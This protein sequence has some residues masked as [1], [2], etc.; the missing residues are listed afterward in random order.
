MES[1]SPPTSRD[2]ASQPPG[3]GHPCSLEEAL[4]KLRRWS[5]HRHE[6]SSNSSDHDQLQVGD[7]WSAGHEGLRVMLLE[8]PSSQNPARC[9][10]DFWLSG[11]A[12]FR[13][14]VWSC[15]IAL[16]MVNC[17]LRQVNKSV[18]R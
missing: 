1:L 6:S 7:T 4:I 18:S 8:K 10:L 15:R 14:Q 9:V 17:A 13:A 3:Q 12:V 5:V 11:I 2:Q 16:Y